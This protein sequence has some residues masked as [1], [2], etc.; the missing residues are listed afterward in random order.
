MGALAGCRP[1]PRWPH[2]AQTR[3]DSPP[4]G[5]PQEG[6]EQIGPRFAC[7]VIK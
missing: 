2:G 6:S 5:N 3:P 4:V 7:V 1:C